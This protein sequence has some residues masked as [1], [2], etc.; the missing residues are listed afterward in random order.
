MYSIGNRN[1]YYI[2]F[3]IAEIRFCTLVIV[4]K[5]GCQSKRLGHGH[6]FDF[7]EIF[8]SRKSILVIVYYIIKTSF[9]NSWDLYT[10]ERIRGFSVDENNLGI[11]KYC[12]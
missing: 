3:S 1:S 8:W 7:H 12:I 10:V 4:S 6:C 9:F 5:M 2:Q 11:L